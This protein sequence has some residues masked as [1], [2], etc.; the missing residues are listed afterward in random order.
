MFRSAAQILPIIDSLTT[1]D[2][3]VE[4]FDDVESNVEIED[5]DTGIKRFFYFEIFMILTGRFSI[6]F[7][8]FGVVFFYLIFVTIDT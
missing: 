6:F 8:I 4:G 7:S 5:T 2:E 1:D 3:S